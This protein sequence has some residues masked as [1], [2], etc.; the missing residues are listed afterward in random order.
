MQESDVEDLASLEGD[1]APSW[2]VSSL[3][4]ELLRP[5]GIQLVATLSSLETNGQEVV[6]WCACS[7]FVPEAELLR[8]AVDRRY[9]RCGIGGS[10]LLTLLAILGEKSVKKLFLEV[11]A[12]NH[13]ALNFYRR[14]GFL[15]VGER[16]GYYRQPA[17]DAFIFACSLP[18]ESQ[19][20][21]AG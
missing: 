19:S 13:A 1:S 8:I 11:R 16:R 2:S 6:G 14:Y 10:L 21:G 7:C 17:D 4:Q 15:K 20:S 18:M 5:R 12:K 9:R 3:R